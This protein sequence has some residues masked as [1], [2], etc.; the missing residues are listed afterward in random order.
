MKSNRWL[1][2]IT[3][4]SC[5]HEFDTCRAFSKDSDVESYRCRVGFFV[6][7]GEKYIFR[8][9]KDEEVFD[10]SLLGVAASEGTE[11]YRGWP[12][13]RGLVE[14]GFRT[15]GGAF[16][17]YGA[18]SKGAAFQRFQK[19]KPGEAIECLIFDGEGGH[20]VEIKIKGQTSICRIDIRLSKG[21]LILWSN[22]PECEQPETVRDLKNE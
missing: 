12:G 17:K 16:Y 15:S 5:L 2:I 11:L 14:I 22:I 21:W 1:V 6:I 9:G 13:P 3:F 18:G 20:R 10:V 4:L 7:K 8:S 19:E